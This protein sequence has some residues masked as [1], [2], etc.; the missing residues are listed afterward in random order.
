MK[1]QT[2][3]RIEE[4]FRNGKQIDSALKRAAIHAKK[5]NALSVA[6]GKKK[7]ARQSK[8]STQNQARLSSIVPLP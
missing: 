8:T 5:S 2:S 3:N 4:A 1:T 6:S 7:A